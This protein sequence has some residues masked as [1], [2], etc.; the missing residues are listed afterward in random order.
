MPDGYRSSQLTSTR[1]AAIAAHKSIAVIAL[2]S[3]ARVTVTS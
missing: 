1:A 2:V 3:M